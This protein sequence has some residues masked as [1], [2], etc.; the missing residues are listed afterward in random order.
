MIIF[1]VYRI[2]FFNESCDLYYYG[3]LQVVCNDDAYDI[4]LLFLTYIEVWELAL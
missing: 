3:F 4:N 2:A 1:V